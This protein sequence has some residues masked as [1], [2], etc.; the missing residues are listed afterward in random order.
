MGKIIGYLFRERLHA[1]MDGY[2]NGNGINQKQLQDQTG[3]SRKAINEY[4]NA[5][6]IPRNDC[7]QLLAQ[8]F[9]VYPEY[10]SGES[11]YKNAGDMAN[12]KLSKEERESLIR[13]IEMMRYFDKE[14][15]LDDYEQGEMTVLESHTETETVDGKEIEVQCIDDCENDYSR[16]LKEIEEY[17]GFKTKQFKDTHAKKQPVKRTK[18]A[19]GNTK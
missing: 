7:L 9:R 15:G 11:K 2:N 5:K 16:L 17:V 3:I 12:K 1:L 4:L 18:K 6:S 10:L 19:R 13:H 14:F 8:F